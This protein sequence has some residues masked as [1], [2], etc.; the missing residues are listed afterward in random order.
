MKE[1]LKSVSDVLHHHAADW[2][3]LKA[4]EAISEP[5]IRVAASSRVPA[6]I[7]AMLEAGASHLVVIRP[8][9]R[10]PDGVVS[11]LD[12]VSHLSR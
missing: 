4:G 6:A 5:C 2:R 7:V 8:G 9:S 11:D 3:R 10:T 1:S 12:L